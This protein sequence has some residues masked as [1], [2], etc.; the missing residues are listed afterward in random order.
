MS[1]YAV[2]SNFFIQAHRV[3]YPLDVAVSFWDMVKSLAVSGR[4]VSIDKVR[5]EIYQ[6][7]DALTIW[8]QNNLPSDF[9]KDSNNVLAEYGQIVSWTM[10][11]N[12]HYMQGAIDEFLDA[13]E[14]D[15]WLI[16]HA[17]KNQYII[18]TYERSDPNLKRK[19]KIP[20]PCNHLGVQYV[21]TMNMFRGLGVKF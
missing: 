7:N 3:L 8:C 19:V 2:D 14:A 10:S 5:N 21:D 12:G 1:I 9:F 20:E 13:D 18:T 15:A 17:M 16:A 11:R 6:N 4:I